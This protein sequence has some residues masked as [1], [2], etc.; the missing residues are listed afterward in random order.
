MDPKKLLKWVLPHGVVRLVQSRQERGY[1]LGRAA[2][3]IQQNAPPLGLAPAAMIDELIREKTKLDPQKNR[4]DPTKA[5]SNRA[6]V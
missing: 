1:R 4:G 2:L 6:C 5:R 3:A